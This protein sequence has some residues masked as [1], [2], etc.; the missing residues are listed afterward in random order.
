MIA[1]T[2]IIPNSLSYGTT[3]VLAGGVAVV[4]D[5]AETSSPVKE[6]NVYINQRDILVELNQR[7]RVLLRN[8][9]VQNVYC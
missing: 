1:T 3:S 8:C 9:C 2:I 7:M 5:E 6:S 4:S